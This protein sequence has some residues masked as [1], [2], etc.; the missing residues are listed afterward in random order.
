MGGIHH[1]RHSLW[2]EI[3]FPRSR[4]LSS[5]YST[6]GPLSELR[7]DTK[8]SFQETR[9]EREQIPGAPA[10]TYCKIPKISPSK[11]SLLFHILQLY[12]GTILEALKKYP[13]FEQSLPSP[14]RLL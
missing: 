11:I 10:N 9:T 14:E 4:L 8:N 6:K 3:V 12:T 7:D 1:I 13:L 5:L 2:A